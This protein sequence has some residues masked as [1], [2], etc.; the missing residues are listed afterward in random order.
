MK[1]LQNDIVM[2]MN[3]NISS[4]AQVFILIDVPIM[5]WSWSIGLMHLISKLYYKAL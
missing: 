2:N 4:H 1:K 3:S 5:T